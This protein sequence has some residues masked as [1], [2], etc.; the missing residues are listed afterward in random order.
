MCRRLFFSWSATLI[1]VGH[2]KEMKIF[3]KNLQGYAGDLH[4][5][6]CKCNHQQFCQNGQVYAEN[7]WFVPPLA[8]V[9]VDQPVYSRFMPE[10]S[11]LHHPDHMIEVFHQSF[12][13]QRQE[14]VSWTVLSS[15]LRLPVLITKAFSGITY[16]STNWAYAQIDLVTFSGF[17]PTEL[18]S[19]SIQYMC[20]GLRQSGLRLSPQ[21]L[22]ESRHSYA[23][24]DQ[25]KHSRIMPGRIY[26]DRFELMLNKTCQAVRV[27]TEK[28]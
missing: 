25:E 23:G 18:Y 6:L 15:C 10:N 21:S 14:S 7:A 20:Y 17:T 9:R 4:L 19:Y 2:P 27:Y 24:V 5:D 13:D 26:I 8:S 3:Y 22:F 1:K 28:D 12:V 16:H 11:Y